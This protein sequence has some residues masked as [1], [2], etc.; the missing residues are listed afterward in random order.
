MLEPISMKQLR[1]RIKRR[2]VTIIDVRPREEYLN[3]HLPGAVSIPLP[4]LKNEIKN[5]PAD[6]EIV[7]YCRGKYCVMAPEAAKVL[8]KKGFKIT[9]LQDDVNSWRFAGLE[10]ER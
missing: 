6:K 2:N 10:L 9:I 5:V 8:S 3:G 7:A 1:G 4:E